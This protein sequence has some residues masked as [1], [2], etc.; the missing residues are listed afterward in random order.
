MMA[1]SGRWG[2]SLAVALVVHLLMAVAV[3]V[4]G[5]RFNRTP[6]Q[7][8]EVTLEGGG[9]GA[10]AQMQQEVGPVEKLVEQTEEVRP[11]DPEEIVDERLKPVIK[12]QKPV[13]KSSNATANIAATAGGGNGSGTGGGEGS[14]QGTGKG[15]GVGSGEGRGVP[16]QPPRILRSSQ[17]K[18]PSS[19][20]SKNIEGIVSVRMLV[21]AGGK[22]ESA[23][24]SSSSG[25]DALDQAAVN[26]VYSWRFSPAKDTYGT[27]VP[28]YITIPVR[29]NL[30]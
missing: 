2:R 6:P 30:K 20:R 13:A 8:L 7:I 24:V 23:S 5:Y 29:F 28:C 26:G 9:G 22:V 18:Y 10:N 25:N 3:G 16:A 21:N 27:A 4:I 14:G 1:L 12:K 11:P 19:A 15:D 17:P